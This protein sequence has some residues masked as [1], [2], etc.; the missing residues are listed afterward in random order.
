MEPLFEQS[1]EALCRMAAAGDGLAEECLMTRY[2]RLVRACTRPYFLAGGDREDLIQE[3]MIGLL[4]A[5]RGFDSKRESG[6][7]T[8]AETCVQNRL[9]SAVRN[10]SRGKHSP[11]NQSLSLDAPLFDEENESYPY[12][13]EPSTLK[14]PE[15]ALIDREEQEGRMEALR[16]ELS[17]FEKAVLDFYLDGLSY[18][19]I[20]L[21]VGKSRKAV[22]NGIQRIRRKAA[23][24][25]SFGD[26]SES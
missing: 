4:S 11:L 26:S 25:F 15:D 17:T 21:Q 6:F 14:T 12:G 24:F 9:R 22:D 19:E 3:G 23:P 2:S 16:G 13:V 20:A 8:Y 10:A 18:E 1:D 5:V 7:R